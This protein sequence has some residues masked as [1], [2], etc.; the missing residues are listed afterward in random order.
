MAN[1]DNITLH[2]MMPTPAGNLIIF[3]KK[4]PGTK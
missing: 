4:T 2:D 1:T 3:A